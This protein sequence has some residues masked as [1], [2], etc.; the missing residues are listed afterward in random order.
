MLQPVRGCDE[1]SRCTT[2]TRAW[3][4]HPF[5]LQGAPDGLSSGRTTRLQKTTPR[6]AQWPDSCVDSIRGAADLA[7]RVGKTHS[8]LSS[9]SSTRR[10]VRRR[11]H[12]CSA[13]PR[14]QHRRDPGARRGRGARRSHLLRRASPL[15]A[16]VLALGLGLN[17]RFAQPARLVRGG[18]RLLLFL[19]RLGLRVKRLESLLGT[20]FS[21]ACSVSAVA[22]GLASR[23]LRSAATARLVFPD[24]C[25]S[26]CSRCVRVR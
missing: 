9:S 19:E 1:R 24:A 2:H 3:L 17:R 22:G 4:Q 5:S 15:A 12:R 18:P 7:D 14:A 8:Q 13:S 23:R 10:I 21:T 20:R 11:P 16:A 6:A 26:A 25:C